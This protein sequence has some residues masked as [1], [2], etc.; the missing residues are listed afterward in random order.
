MDKRTQPFSFF[1]PFQPASG[2]SSSM[3]AIGSP[4]SSIIAPPIEIRS[5]FLSPLITAKPFTN[6]FYFEHEL[7]WIGYRSS[8]Q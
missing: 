5:S 3:A 8:A 4:L 2:S 7:F 1:R 6:I